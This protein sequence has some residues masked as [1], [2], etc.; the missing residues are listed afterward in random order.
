MR[1]FSITQTATRICPR[2]W[3]TAPATLIPTSPN[4][5]HFLSSVMIRILHA[6]PARLYSNTAIFPNKMFDRM[7]R[8]TEIT[9]VDFR[10][11]L[12]KAMIV[13]RFASP[14]FTPG[15]AMWIGTR[16]SR[17]D[18]IIAS[19]IRTPQSAILWLLFNFG[20]SLVGLSFFF[21]DICLFPSISIYSLISTT[22]LCGRQIIVSPVRLIARCFSQ[23][24]S[25][26]SASCTVTLPSCTTTV[27]TPASCITS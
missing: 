17:Y 13:T 5:R 8:P 7:I 16:L 9:I 4:T 18:K 11:N 1:T 22:N 23:I 6:A 20:W 15:T 2:L 12:C 14:S 3:N 26:Q 19:A 27:L 24:L 21:N 10:S 25:G